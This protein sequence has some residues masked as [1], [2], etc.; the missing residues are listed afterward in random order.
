VIKDFMIQMGDP[1]GT[2]EG[3]KSIWGRPFK[4]E[5]HGRIKFNHRG[6]VAMANENK[7]NSNHSQFFVTLGPCEWLDRKHTIFGKVTGNTIYNVTRM[8][9]V[10]TDANNRPIDNIFIIST[11]V[12]WN[13]F[14]DIIPRD[15]SKVEDSGRMASKSISEEDRKKQLQ[16]S[17]KVSKLMNYSVYLRVIN[18]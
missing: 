18:L 14:D 16:S 1:T 9:D 2:G 17:R 10:E 7:P 3:G 13:P 11:E 15:L 6:Q 12:L 4:D 8:S 5:L